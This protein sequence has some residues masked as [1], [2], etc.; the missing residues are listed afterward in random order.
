LFG[1]EIEV[2]VRR[3]EVVAFVLTLVLCCL[4]GPDEGLG[5][6]VSV[7]RIDSM[8]SDDDTLIL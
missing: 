3:M 6:N 2:Y 8:C 1:K 4:L 5:C 7:G